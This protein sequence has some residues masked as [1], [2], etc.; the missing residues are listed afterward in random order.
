MRNILLVPNLRRKAHKQAVISLALVFAI[1]FAMFIFLLV[2][3]FKNDIE[4]VSEVSGTVINIEQNKDGEYF[5][6]L[7][8]KGE[9]R[10][11]GAVSS[12][13]DETKIEKLSGEDVVLYL[14]YFTSDNDIIGFS[15]SVYSIDKETAFNFVLEN[16]MSGCIFLGTITAIFLAGLIAETVI[17]AKSKKEVR[18]DVFKLMNE[19]TKG[20]VTI[21]PIRKNILKLMG[22]PLILALFLLIPICIYSEKNLLVLYICLGLCLAC[23]VATIVALIVMLPKIQRREFEYY[24]N[25]LDG[26]RN[27]PEKDYSDIVMDVGNMLAFQINEDGLLYNEINEADFII[28]N[29]YG[30]L[31]N[32]DKELLR[33]EILTEIK[34]SKQNPMAKKKKDKYEI[35][36]AEQS[37]LADGTLIKYSELNLSTK[38]CF[39]VTNLPIAIFVTSNLTE[40]QYPTMQ[41]DIFLE[42][43]EEL[44]YY[45]KKYDIHVSGLE[46][47]LSHKMEYMKKYCGNVYKGKICYVEI[48]DDDEKVLFNKEKKSN[49]K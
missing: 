45:L 19:N 2:D 33:N 35:N 37:S 18:G 22:I 21:S 42:L 24:S 30:D 41:N 1:F 32:E 38:V 40:E 20:I 12:H 13:V 43:S 49:K 28:N 16:Y 3:Y 48:T 47:V 10:L 27:L 29:F 36:Y 39:R 11:V 44:Y 4:K 25:L 5:L 46:K 6:T 8:G 34:Q 31:P 17:F 14:Y 23:I 9:Y 15:S 26:L 7:N